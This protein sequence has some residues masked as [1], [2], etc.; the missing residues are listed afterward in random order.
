MCLLLNF[1]ITISSILWLDLMFWTYIGPPCMF[2]RNWSNHAILSDL[3]DYIIIYIRLTTPH[4]CQVIYIDTEGTF[5]PDR[6][7]QIAEAKGVSAEAAMDNIVC[8]RCALAA[9]G[10][11]SWKLRH[12]KAKVGSFFVSSIWLWCDSAAAFPHFPWTNK[13]SESDDGLSE[14]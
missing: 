9:T 3:S 5:R 13:L 12:V 8:A 4:S 11:S 6:V 7:R 2:T 14:S 1:L 10:F